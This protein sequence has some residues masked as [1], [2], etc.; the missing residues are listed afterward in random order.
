MSRNRDIAKILGLTEAENTGNVSL[1]AGGGGGSGVTNADSIGLFAAVPDSGTLH[2]AKNTKALYLYDGNE[3]DRVFSGPNEALSFTTSLASTSTVSPGDSATFT[4]LAASD[5]EGFPITYSYETVPSNPVGLDSASGTANSGVI[6]NNDGTF[7]L[8]GASGIDSAAQFTFRAKATDGTHVSTTSSVVSLVGAHTLDILFDNSCVALYKLDNDGTDVSGNFDA[9]GYKRGSGGYSTTSKYGSHS[10]APLSGD[11]VL[12]LPDVVTSYPFTVSAWVR[13]N[14]LDNGANNIVTNTAIGSQ[15]VTICL[16]DWANT[17]NVQP[18][19]MY[20]GNG[21]WYWSGYTF[22]LNT[23]YHLTYSVAGNNSASSAVYIN[24]SASGLTA[25]N[26]GSSHGGTAGWAL[27]GNFTGNANENFDG[28]LDQ[29]R[30]FN[31]ALTA[32]EAATLYSR[33]G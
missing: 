29:V 31:K 20:G 1:G 24:G 17:N 30:I 33:G 12:D 19:I 15:R 23:W 22:A 11:A 13:L 8:Y 32:S 5:F 7:N 10:F 18:M 25:N 2:Y 21:H 14:N 3:Y 4:V 6:N 26:G 27:G 28:Y 9:S 16:Y